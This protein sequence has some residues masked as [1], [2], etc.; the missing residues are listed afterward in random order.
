M[1]Q[2]HLQVFLI[3]KSQDLYLL[4]NLRAAT[5]EFRYELCQWSQKNVGKY[6]DNDNIQN[7]YFKP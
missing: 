6:M 5:H 2:D 3:F 4:P 1:N 7:I